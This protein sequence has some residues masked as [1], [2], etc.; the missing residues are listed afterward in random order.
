MES[1][2]QDLEDRFGYSGKTLGGRYHVNR[3]VATGAFAIVYHAHTESGQDVAIKVSRTDQEGALFRFDREIKVMESLP[4]SPQLVGYRSHGTTPDGRLFLA[5][6]YVSGPTLSDW[7]TKRPVL[8]ATEACACVGQIALA[9]QTLHRFKIVHRDLKPS[10]VLLSSDGLVKLFDFGLI[11]DPDG[12]LQMFET[13]DILG[14][15]NLAEEVERGMLVGTPEYM[16]SEQ[17]EDAKLDGPPSRTCAASDV[18]SAGIILYRLITGALPFPMVCAGT[19]PTSQEILA[20]LNWRSKIATKDL[21]RPSGTTIDG[22]I[23]EKL[24]NILSRALSTVPWL[25][26]KNGKALADELFWYLTERGDEGGSTSTAAMTNRRT[27]TERGPEAD[28]NL[29]AKELFGDLDLSGSW[30]WQLPLDKLDPED[31]G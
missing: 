3:P 31:Q 30:S 1:W 29:N 19:R 2:Q 25:R 21:P 4:A 6:E 17:F 10:N 15:K 28:E 12:M 20:Y 8:T 24:W 18:F 23:D 27:S 11:L 9:L 13:K 22:D 5:M 7:L 16:P 26:Q 14:G